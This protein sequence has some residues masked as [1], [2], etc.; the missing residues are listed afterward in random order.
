ME[1]ITAKE[2][3]GIGYFLKCRRKVL[4]ICREDF[5]RQMNINQEILSNWE[6]EDLENIGLYEIKKLAKI[7]NYRPK[8]FIDGLPME[9]YEDWTNFINQDYIDSKT[10][11][12]A[13]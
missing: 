8:L 6:N 7:L 4:G 3:I 12:N 2:Y 11:A 9:A 13:Y 5:C 1:T 10:F